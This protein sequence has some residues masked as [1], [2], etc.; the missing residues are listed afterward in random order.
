MRT[1]SAMPANG[2]KTWLLACPMRFRKWA[3]SVHLALIAVLSLAPA[4][5][6]PPSPPG[7][8]G[9]DKAVHV[10]LYG[11][12][13]A[14]LRWAAGPRAERRAAL[15]LPIAGAA[16]GLILE[17]LQPLIGGEGRSF[18]WGDA[19]A[20][21]IGVALFWW[22]AGRFLRWGSDPGGQPADAVQPCAGR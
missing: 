2:L 4:W 3:C 17:G 12:L 5:L 20:N 14:L 1:A 11:V 21:L 19:A 8:P 13:G 10:G 16:Y 6:F 15:W 7:V 22:A 9:I 18:S